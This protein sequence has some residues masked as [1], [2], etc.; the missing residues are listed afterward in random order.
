VERVG[1]FFVF[2]QITML[3]LSVDIS[4]SSTASDPYDNG[5]NITY[6]DESGAS[7]D[8]FSDSLTIAGAKLDNYLVSS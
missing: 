3:T 8:L 4:Q 7:G 2:C 1:L 6:V 5:L